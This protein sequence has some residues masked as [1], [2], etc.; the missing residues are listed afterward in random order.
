[1]KQL[2]PDCGPLLTYFDYIAGTSVGGIFDLVL[3]HAKHPLSL[4]EPSASSLLK[5]SAQVL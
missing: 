3:S 5:T 1:M 4:F 2:Q